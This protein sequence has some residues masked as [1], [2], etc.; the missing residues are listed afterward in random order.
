MGWADVNQTGAA[1]G[2]IGQGETALPY[3]DR[4]D[5][6]A[7][8]TKEFP[9]QAEARFFYGYLRVLVVQQIQ[10]NRQQGACAGADDQ[11]LRSGLDTAG[12]IY[13]Y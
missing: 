13:I 1:L 2:Q 4:Y 5:F 9:S 6:K 10:Q 12:L 8:R 7:A 3:R 11:V